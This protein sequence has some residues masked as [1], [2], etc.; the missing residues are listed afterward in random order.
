MA[1]VVCRWV[2]LHKSGSQTFEA[3]CLQLDSKEE[4]R[5]APEQSNL[6]ENDPKKEIEALRQKHTVAQEMDQA[7]H[8]L[9]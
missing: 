5:V 6:V 4:H 7:I 9:F 2:K 8:G 1:C 3:H